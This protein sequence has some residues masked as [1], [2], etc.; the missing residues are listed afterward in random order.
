MD[1]QMLLAD[2]Y[3]ELKLYEEAERHLKLAAA[4]CPVRFMPLYQLAELYRETGR[5]A[6]ALALARQI[7]NK[8]I[9]IPSSTI[10]A[11]KNKTEQLIREVKTI[12]DSATESG[13]EVELFNNIMHRQGKEQ[14]VNSPCSALPP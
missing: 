6:E 10:N 12:Y 7:L 14:E 8:E 9:K 11:I 1:V 5:T 3:R 4:M 2:N 13:T